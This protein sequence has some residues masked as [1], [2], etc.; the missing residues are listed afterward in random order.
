MNYIKLLFSVAVI[1]LSTQ[2]IKSQVAFITSNRAISTVS[3]TDSDA[4]LIIKS[5]VK[6]VASIRIENGYVYITDSDVKEEI[7]ISSID[8]DEKKQMITVYRTTKDKQYATIKF[9]LEKEFS[10]ICVI[11]QGVMFSYYPITETLTK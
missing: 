5:D 2:N 10:M 6:K 11:T 9:F 7:K 1:V 4:G 3:L 8:R